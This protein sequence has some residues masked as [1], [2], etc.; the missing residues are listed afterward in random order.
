MRKTHG[1]PAASHSPARFRPVPDPFHARDHRRQRPHPPVDPRRRAP[2]SGAH[3]LWRA[4]V[5]A[6]CSARSPAA[7]VVFL[8][9]HGH[10]HTIP[11]HRVNYRANLW[12]LKQ[13]GASAILAVA[14]VGA[15]R[16]A[17]PGDLVLPHQLIDYTRDRESSFFDGGDQRVV[18][19]DFTHPVCAGAS[20][21]V[22]RRIA[23]GGHSA[24]R[25][26]RL[27]RRVGAAARDRRR[28][29]PDGT[30]RRDA[31]RNDR[32][33]R[34][35]ARAR[36]RAAV[37]GHRRSRQSRGGT[38][39]FVAAGLDGRIAKVLEKAMDKVRALLDHVTPLI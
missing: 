22:P 17:A 5:G 14:S 4:V 12:A 38:G 31:R 26:R 18:H 28:D 33:A 21:Q 11:P 23:R 2:R 29:R 7:D 9:R 25:R 6:A 30:G 20:R 13:R 10:G 34:S 39:R 1:A 36:A 16:G 37:R 35:N 32:H 3:A 19:V 8:A 24:R 27:W 15:I